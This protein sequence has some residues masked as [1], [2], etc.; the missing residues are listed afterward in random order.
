MADYN[1]TNND[2]SG[3]HDI[4]ADLELNTIR[5][6][7]QSYL[8]HDWQI[9]T[10]V[11]S[12]MTN[13]SNVSE[14]EWPWD[15]MTTYRVICDVFLS[16]P[17]SL[18]GIVGNILSFIVMCKQRQSL[19]TSILLQGLA[20]A[21]TLILTST[22]LIRSMRYLC[23]C[24]LT[25]VAYTRAYRYI[26]RWLYPCVFL[27]RLSTT[28][29]TTLLTMDRYIAVSHPLQA[30]RL[31]T[32]SKTYR[33]ILLIILIS[34]IFSIPRFFE[35]TIDEDDE[36]GFTSTSFSK[37]RYY[38][39]IYKILLFFIF[40]YLLPMALLIVANTKLLCTL[41]RADYRRARMQNNRRDKL[42]YTSKYAVTSIV[43]TV[44]LIS[45]V[46][47]VCAMLSHILYS[48]AMCFD[49]LSFLD[50]H[51]RIS[52]N[53]S[54]LM[55]TFNS[56]INFIIYCL[57]SRNFRVTFLRMFRCRRSRRCMPPKDNY[58]QCTAKLTPSNYIF[59]TKFPI[60]QKQPEL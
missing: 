11:P 33:N 12:M 3:L 43:V 4:I 2:G 58:K 38:T 53:I 46:C 13:N 17:I 52:S 35:Y 24:L 5:I 15:S 8:V 39:I 54:N 9:Q 55:I 16:M 14:C 7:N 59:L 26:F 25:C 41:R 57:Y 21:D 51:R 1:L 31:C 42:A 22:L 34:V 27:F 37:N 50:S 47:N 48:L 19:T 23:T 10:V 40:M 56:A 60:R 44:V 45:I 6:L 49:H 20:V 18:L 30:H 29:L 36:F 32:V 28:W